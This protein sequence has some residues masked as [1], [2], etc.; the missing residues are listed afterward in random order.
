MSLPLFS[1]STVVNV[2]NGLGLRFGFKAYGVY[3]AHPPY[4]TLRPTPKNKGGFF[5]RCFPS[6]ACAGP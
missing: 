4:R 6:P 1:A 2:Y 5:A 3:R